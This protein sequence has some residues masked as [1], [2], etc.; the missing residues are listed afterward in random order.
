MLSA[1]VFLSQTQIC[2]TIKAIN[3]KF[4][5]FST[6][7]QAACQVISDSN[8][9]PQSSVHFWVRW[10]GTDLNLKP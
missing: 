6:P 10:E 4:V 2:C 7:S 3:I 5:H 9:F 1:L 8:Q